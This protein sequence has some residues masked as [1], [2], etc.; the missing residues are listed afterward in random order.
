[1]KK[2]FSAIVCALVLVSLVG[3]KKAEQASG[4]R[5]EKLKS[6]GKIVVYTNPEFPP[7]EYVGEGGK[8]VGCEIDIVHK[9]ADRIGVEAELVSA[10]F[11]SIIGA[12]QA[13]KA[14]LGAS[15]FTINDERKE[16]VDFSDPFIVSVQYLVIPEN[17]PIAKV[18]DFAGKKIA[19]QNGTTGFMMVEDAI[20]KG[21][22]KGKGT[23]L[24]S[25]NNAPD[26]VVAM[27]N[28]QADA[29]V[30]DEL[31]AQMLAKKNPGMKTIPMVKADGQGLDAPEE[32]GMIVAKGNQDIIDIIN[33]VIKEMKAD[34]SLT[35][36]FEVHQEASSK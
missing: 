29:V 6:A 2:V 33:E 21:I 27:K 13:G 23:E 17:S 10:E 22:L 9:I 28:G 8:I 14:D 16:K 7:Y 1:M 24:K 25:Y 20:N 19:G 12:V 3:C 5:L 11:D 32:F 18:E 31:V 30:I 15:G 34:G 26:A 36:S 35:K 4:G